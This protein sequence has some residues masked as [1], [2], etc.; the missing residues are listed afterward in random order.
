MI[1]KSIKKL[2][3]SIVRKLFDKRND[4]DKDKNTSIKDENIPLLL[5]TMYTFN[6]SDISN[7][8]LN[9]HEINVLHKSID[10][11]EIFNDNEDKWDYNLNEN[12]SKNLQNTNNNKSNKEKSLILYNKNMK[13]LLLF[14]VA[15]GLSGSMIGIVICQYILPSIC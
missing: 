2:K 9:A 4:E 15:I 12:N 5:T 11:I 10:N 7:K 8:W 6:E 14:G 3:F 1:R 13:F